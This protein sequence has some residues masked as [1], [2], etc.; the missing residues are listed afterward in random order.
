MKV[1]N[2]RPVPAHPPTVSKLKQSWKGRNDGRRRQ[3]APDTEKNTKKSTTGLAPE[4]VTRRHTKQKI[5]VN[6][7]V[8]LHG[9]DIRSED[10]KKGSPR[11]RTHTAKINDESPRGR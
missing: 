10:Q 9:V 2:V 3:S 4:G 1:R 5:S 11:V 8:K 7:E 6:G